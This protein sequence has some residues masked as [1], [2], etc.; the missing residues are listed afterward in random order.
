MYDDFTDHF[1]CFQEP[2]VASN[3]TERDKARTLKVYFEKFEVVLTVMK[4]QILNT[5]NT[6][7]QYL[8]ALQMDLS[9][10]L[11]EKHIP[12]SI[13]RTGLYFEVTPLAETL[14]S[15]GDK[16]N[17][18]KSIG[19]RVTENNNNN[20]SCFSEAFSLKKYT[21]AFISVEIWFVKLATTNDSNAL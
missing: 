1:G 17:V 14:T 20:F 4:S 6:V 19:L 3:K 2:P 21:V 7:S 10:S 12:I 13:E 11:T 16:I 9:N 18:N 8:Q 5:L 15:I